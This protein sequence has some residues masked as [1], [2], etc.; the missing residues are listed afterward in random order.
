MVLVHHLARTMGLHRDGEAYGLSPFEAEMHR[1][2]WWYIC[3]L[4]HRTAEVCRDEHAV[5]PHSFDAR[6]P[7]HVD[8]ADLSSE[9]GALPSEREGFS[10]MT[11]CL[12]RYETLQTVWRIDGDPPL[13]EKQAAIS[14]LGLRLEDR[15][16]TF[17]IR[18][19]PSS[20][21]CCSQRA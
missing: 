20:S 21:R 4:D 3:I 8:D 1:R 13:A 18:R 16:L 17:A 11:F 9:M 15:Y 7:L 19:S 14:E 6:L 2:L 10:E 12:V 5:R